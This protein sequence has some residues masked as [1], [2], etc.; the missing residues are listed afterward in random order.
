MVGA[1]LPQ[2]KENNE[3]S[4][5]ATFA[6]PAESRDAEDKVEQAVEEAVFSKHPAI[7]DD[8]EQEAPSIPV[9]LAPT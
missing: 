8:K 4:M 5:T 6:A 3:F 7:E 2:A 9:V 1:E